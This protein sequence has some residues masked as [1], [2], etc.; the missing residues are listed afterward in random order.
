MTASWSWYIVVLTVANVAGVVWLLLATAKRRPGEPDDSTT[1]HT[2]DEDLT[3]YNHALPRW[4]FGMF[5]LSVLFGA[6]YLVFYPGLGANAG[7]LGWTS[8]GEVKADLDENNRKLETLFAHF[9]DQPIDVLAHDA[10]ALALG[11]NVFANNCVACHGSD[12]RGAKSYP[13]LTDADWL[14]GGA[15][16]QVL[17]TILGGRSGTMPPLAAALGEQ[18][19]NEVANYV[20]SLSGG[21]ADTALVEA[22]KPRFALCAACHGADG[23]GNAI[24]GA[25]NLTDRI[26]LYGGTLDDIKASIRDGRSGKMP[27]WEATLGK[28][29]ARLAAAWVL[30]Q[31]QPSAQTPAA[32][33]AASP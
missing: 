6:G 17:T 33:V 29:R 8:A 15:P 11:H 24:V 22:G 32:G 18:G 20:L 4:W 13:N 19:I 26:W 10:Q 16:D 27:A 30:A 12:A 9:R 3:E 23:K 5:V 7:T 14:Y 21:K 31:S 2:W 28:D 25:P 1:G